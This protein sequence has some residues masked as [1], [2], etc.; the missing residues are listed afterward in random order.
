[1]AMKINLLPWR[2]ELKKEREIRFAIS[3]GIAL[4]V[5]GVIFFGVHVYVAGLIDFQQ[6]RNDFL[7]EEIKRADDKIAEIKELEKEKDRLFKRMDVIQKLQTSRPEIV[8][9]FD[10]LVNTLPEGV[11]FKTL[12]QKGN[13][14]TITGFA[15]SS[16]RVSSLMNRMDKSE[17]LTKPNL[18][19]VEK[20]EEKGS[21]ASKSLVSRKMSEFKL[22]ITQAAPKT[23]E[24]LEEEG[25]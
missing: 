7:N 6:Q 16:A 21:K 22:V 14:I 13:E 23:K 20:I 4:A 12:E 10:E 11:Y 1:M 3:A 15:Q 8:H 9:V 2:K 18:K 24:D 17:W 25:F 5:V 19:F